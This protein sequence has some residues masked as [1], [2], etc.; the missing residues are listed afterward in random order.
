[1]DALHYLLK[2]NLCWIIFYIV[3]WALFRN[4]TFFMANRLYLIASLFA[5]M[6]IPAVE[7]RGQVGL[8]PAESPLVSAANLSATSNAVHGSTVP[9]WQLV[10][11]F[12]YLAGVSLMLL[13]LLRALIRIYLVIR[14]AVPVPTEECRLLINQGGK[15][16]SGS[17]SFLRWMVVSPE[18]YEEYFESI[19]AHELAHIR[20]WHSLDILLIEVLKV[21]FWFNPVLWLYKSSL[22]QLHEFLA[23]EGAEDKDRY[24]TFMISYARR[25][26][27]AAVTSNFFHK[28]LLKQ[29]IQMIYKQRTPGWMGWKYVS[30][31][32]LLAAT[33]MLMATRNYEHSKPAIEKQADSQQKVN[34]GSVG[35]LPLL[36]DDATLVSD[37]SKP[38]DKL[39]KKP[40]IGVAVS[41]AGVHEATDAGQQNLIDSLS[42]L[43]TLISRLTTAVSNDDLRNADS[44]R[45]EINPIIWS[46][47]ARMRK[48]QTEAKLRS[49]GFA[50]LNDAQQ[51]SNVLDR[52]RSGMI[53]TSQEHFEAQWDYFGKIRKQ[54]E[55]VLTSLRNKINDATAEEEKRTQDQII[56]DLITEGVATDKENLSFR[57]HNMFLIVNG[58]E[59]SEEL[60]Q[61]LKSRYIKYSWMEWVYKWDGTTGHRFTGVRFNG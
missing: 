15:V 50:A 44:L 61:K 2:V 37:K 26:L 19:F 47:S 8:L 31:F 13:L 35:I 11:P 42:E 51:S 46:E 22:E 39:L 57:L 36:N 52:L 27:S 9:D 10:I 45:K 23:D 53:E 56:D 16:G 14:S 49:Q 40:K 41:F 21:F 1:M 38:D 25:A 28:S 12:V 60:H 32:P 55:E 24:A 4:H 59:Q 30:I 3:Y 6:L 29:R 33:V 58:V 17:F 20:Q 5:G 18:D 43:R 7:M 34:P 48:E 54:F